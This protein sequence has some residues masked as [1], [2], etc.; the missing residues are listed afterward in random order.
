MLNCR[1]N[2][3]H[4]AKVGM[5]VVRK[6]V[7]RFV[8]NWHF[9]KIIADLNISNIL[10]ICSICSDNLHNLQQSHCQTD[11]P[12]DVL[13]CDLVAG[14]VNHKAAL[15]WANKVYS[16]SKYQLTLLAL[17]QFNSVTFQR[18]VRGGT[19][20]IDSLVVSHSSDTRETSAW[21][22]FGGC[23]VPTCLAVGPNQLPN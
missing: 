22:R 15:C 10:L 2:K 14:D 7:L 23:P 19:V 16:F 17:R 18:L 1:G 5:L 11:Y 20:D 9:S 12:R 13:S 4:F 6:E 3:E 8:C 21:N